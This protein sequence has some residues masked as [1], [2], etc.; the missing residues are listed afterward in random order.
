MSSRLSPEDQQKVEQYLA[1][2]LH[3]VERAP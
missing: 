2:P 3:Q 1:S